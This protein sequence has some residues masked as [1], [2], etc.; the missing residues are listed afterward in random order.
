MNRP[1][2]EGTAGNL[3]GSS[4]AAES[5]GSN[6][7]NSFGEELI[8]DSCHVLPVGG[9]GLL[10]YPGPRG[11]GNAFQGVSLPVPASAY[12]LPMLGTDHDRWWEGSEYTQCGS[13]YKRL[14]SQGRLIRTHELRI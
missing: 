14:Q 7:G 9:V 11:P 2:P 10:E 1:F 13:H 8:I 4:Q 5:H 6:D 12:G 3:S